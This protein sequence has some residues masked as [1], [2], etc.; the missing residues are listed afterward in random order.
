M[1]VGHRFFLKASNPPYSPPFSKGGEGGLLNFTIFAISIKIQLV[2][3][4]LITC[5]LHHL[6]RPIGDV[7]K[8]QFDHI[9]AGFTDD[10]VMVIL[11][12]TEFIFNI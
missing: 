1:D 11:Q 4:H 6:I 5:R 7:T 9:P 2:V 10:M 8:I 12:L 3:G